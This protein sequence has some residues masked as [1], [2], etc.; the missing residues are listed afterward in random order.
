MRQTVCHGHTT[1]LKTP[2]LNEGQQE[3]WHTDRPN[4]FLDTLEEDLGYLFQAMLHVKFYLLTLTPRCH[5]QAISAYLG[6]DSG[7]T[8]CQPLIGP[9]L[10]SFHTREEGLWET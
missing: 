5:L 9:H 7:T 3:L 8:V 10:V 6:A 4:G 1:D 2:H